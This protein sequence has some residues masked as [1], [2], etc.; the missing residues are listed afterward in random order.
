MQTPTHI[1]VGTVPD[2]AHPGDGLLIE[3]WPDGSGTIA[4]RSSPR[5]SWGPPD[6]LEPRPTE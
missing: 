2:E 4:T 6:D 5:N 3:V 1:F